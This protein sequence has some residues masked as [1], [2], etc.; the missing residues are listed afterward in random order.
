MQYDGIAVIISD[1]IPG[2]RRRGTVYDVQASAA[3]SEEHEEEEEEEEEVSSL[4]FYDGAKSS[5][6]LPP[7]SPPG[8]R[9]RIDILG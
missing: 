1:R 2:A 5:M 3:G 8:N 4:R 6:V 7:C 9:P